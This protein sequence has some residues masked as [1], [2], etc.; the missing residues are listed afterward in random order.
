MNTDFL[1]AIRDLEKERNISADVI[2]DAIDAALVSAYKKNFGIQQAE[3]VRTEINRETGEFH[4][5]SCREIVEEVTDP[6]S[7]IS[8]EEAEKINVLYEPGDIVEEEVTPANFG[9]IAAQTAKQVVVQRMR[10][11]ERSVIFE[12]YTNM[13]GEIMSG[14]VQRVENRNVYLDVGKTEAVLNR[15]EQ[16][17]GETYHHGDRIKVYMLNVRKSP[18][19]PQVMVSRTHPGLLKRL[20]EQEVPEIYDGTVEIKS[21]AREAGNRSKIAVYSENENVDSLGACVG[22]KGMRVQAIVDEL[23]GE[24]IDI[25]NWSEDPAEYIDNALNPAKVLEVDIASDEKYAQVIVPD[26]QLSLAIGKEGQNARLAVRLTGWKIDIKSASEMGLNDEGY[27]LHP[28]EGADNG[29]YDE[30]DDSA[31]YVDGSEF[32]KDTSIDEIVEEA[33][34]NG[35]AALEEDFAQ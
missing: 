16:I 3:N 31:D 13:E 21:I 24:K 34:A 1:D 8:L 20:F 25:V 29:E 17:P 9:R 26:V 4:V 10:E 11:A 7:Q 19:G 2:F 28:E 23:N 12:E 30:A 6:Q 32:P 18:R 27:P 15:Q 35:E 14:I 22:A 33:A 5:F